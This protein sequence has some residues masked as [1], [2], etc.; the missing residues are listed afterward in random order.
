MQARLVRGGDTTQFPATRD[1]VAGE[2]LV[3]ANKPFVAVNDTLSGVLGTFYNQGSFEVS[4]PTTA[5]AL[6]S[7]Q[8]LYWDDTNNVAS[9]VSSV[10]A[11]AFTNETPFGTGA[12][13]IVVGLSDDRPA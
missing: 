13:T 10:G 4:K 12:G 2:V 8:K 3:I 1:V 9:P 7:G 6:T 5:A 11:L